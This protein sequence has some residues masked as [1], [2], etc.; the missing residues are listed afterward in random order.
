MGNILSQRIAAHEHL[1]IAAKQGNLGAMDAW[2]ALAQGRP[3]PP[4]VDVQTLRGRAG[5]HHY[6][7]LHGRAAA[8]EWLLARGAD[9]N[10]PNANGACALH[11]AHTVRDGE[12]RGRI[13]AALR[14]AG[15]DARREGRSPLWPGAQSAEQLLSCL[16]YTSPSPRDRQ[17]SRMPSSA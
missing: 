4:G 13:V 7:V 14:G 6:A 10:R 17:K 3:S 15:A 11:F 16:L 5:A 1:A 9:P 12:A 8:V 2:W